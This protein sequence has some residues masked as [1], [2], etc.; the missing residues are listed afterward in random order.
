MIQK[1]TNLAELSEEAENFQLLQSSSRQQPQTNQTS[2]FDKRNI[3]TKSGDGEQL[4]NYQFN[5]KTINCY[6]F[7]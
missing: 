3:N 2:E 5:P 4:I 7:I 1:Q 6:I